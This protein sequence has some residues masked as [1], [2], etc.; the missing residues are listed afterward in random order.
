MDDL[1]GKAAQLAASA[2]A[3]SAA[4][5]PVVATTEA[6]GDPG[7]FDIADDDA[8]SRAFSDAGDRLLCG[9]FIVVSCVGMLCLV[10]IV[11]ACAGLDL[12]HAR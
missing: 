11:A 8:R 5:T 4:I 1:N 3:A 12:F 10:E 6:S 9:V 2:S 7:R